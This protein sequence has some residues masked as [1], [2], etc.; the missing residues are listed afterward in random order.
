MTICFKISMSSTMFMFFGLIEKTR[1]PPWL[2]ID[3]DI[4]NFSSETTERN[5]TIF[6]RKQDFNVLYQFCVFWVD[7]KKK[8]AVLSVLSIKVAHCTHV[9]YMWP[10]R[11]LVL[12]D[13]SGQ[14]CL[15]YSTFSDKILMWPTFSKKKGIRSSYV[16][17]SIW[18]LNF[19][20]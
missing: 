10:F 9:H 15:I 4:F 13:I 6:D 7:W 17:Q 19:N 8:M 5:S 16:N 2:L 20:L 3:W 11:P 1:W 14:F 12:Q 18:Y